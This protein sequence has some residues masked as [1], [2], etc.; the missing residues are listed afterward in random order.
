MSNSVPNTSAEHELVE[1]RP[2]SEL[3]VGD[4]VSVT[5]T[6]TLDDLR[7][8]AAATG[9]ANPSMLD[10]KFA[11]SSIYREVIANGMWS[12]AIPLPTPATA[13]RSKAPS[14]LPNMA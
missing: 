3:K 11:D 1:N 2:F 10:P 13:N 4:S 9:D 12:G 5:R 14:W 7:L 8:F 6:I